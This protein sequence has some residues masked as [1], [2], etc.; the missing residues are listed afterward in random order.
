MPRLGEFIDNDDLDN[1]VADKTII[2]VE[3]PDDLSFFYAL[4]GPNVRD[5]LEFKVPESG[6]GY[7]QVKDRVKELRSSDNKKVHG[8]L[9]GEA[10][11]ALGQTASFIESC[12]PL[13]QT[14]DESFDGLVFLSEY[15]LENLLLRHT[16]IANF[17][18]NDVVVADLGTRD[19]GKIQTEFDTLTLRYFLFSLIK[20]AM[21]EFHSD[22]RPCKGVGKIGGE[23]LT[24]QVGAAKL[25]RANVKAAIEP[26]MDWQEFLEEM[27]R[28][29]RL[30][31]ANHAQKALGKDQKRED[32]LRIAD[33]KLLFKHIKNRYNGTAKW[34]GHLH[35]EL[36][37]SP[38]CDRFR[39][40][41]LM[42]TNTRVR[43][44]A[45]VALG[46]A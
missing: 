2:Y 16:H 13:F 8:L 9:D 24:Q 17:I 40:A 7:H 33:G 46:G 18:V 23:F 11:V 30:I 27:H 41:L 1:A 32:A 19:Q 43:Q 37:Q 10:A 44:V 5:R 15:E 20:F 14:N 22:T 3:G 4:T 26:Q 21:I 34:D 35:N 25:M 36:V 38:Y 29:M 39:D 12:E 6:T 45:G 31:R 42:A 28:L